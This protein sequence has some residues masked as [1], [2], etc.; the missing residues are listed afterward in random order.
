M[1]APVTRSSYASGIPRTRRA[2]AKRGPGSAAFETRI[3]VPPR[4]RKAASAPVAAGKTRV[5][6]WSTPKTSHRMTA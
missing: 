3:T 1:S 2:S 4:A 6:S 5:A